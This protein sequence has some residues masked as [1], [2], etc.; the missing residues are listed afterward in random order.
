M[1]LEHVAI[2]TTQLEILKDYYTRYFGGTS[3]Q[4]YANPKT[5]LESYFITF[6]SG[7]KLEIM[8]FPELTENKNDLTRPYQGIIHLAFGVDTML[9]VE[10][11]ARQLEANGFRI[12][13]GPRKTGDGFYEF[14]TVDPDGNKIEVATKYVS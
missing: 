8:S 1:I 10:A 12:L 6:E 11:K 7:A 13:R 4:K 2:L 9:E 3:N 5:S 14:E